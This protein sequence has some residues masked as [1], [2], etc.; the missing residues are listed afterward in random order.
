MVM[1]EIR[2]HKIF[3]GYLLWFAVTVIWRSGPVRYFT[4]PALLRLYGTVMEEVGVAK[5]FYRANITVVGLHVYERCRGH[6]IF[7]RASATAVGS[8]TVIDV[9]RG[10]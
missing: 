6:N 10:L 4:E 2:A 5:I 1:G 7:H 8:H 3:T 9:V